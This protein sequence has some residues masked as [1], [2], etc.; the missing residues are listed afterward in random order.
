VCVLVF[1]LGVF[2]FVSCSLE[3]LHLFEMY[4]YHVSVLFSISYTVFGKS[5]ALMKGVRSDVYERLTLSLFHRNSQSVYE[6]HC[7]KVQGVSGNFFSRLL[8]H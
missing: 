1:L 6:L 8:L 7:D 3:F 5:L 2:Y 4:P